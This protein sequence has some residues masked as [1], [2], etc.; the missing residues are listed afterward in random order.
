[1]DKRNFLM[2]VGDPFQ[3]IWPTYMAEWRHTALGD[4]Q[5]CIA[6]SRFFLFFSFA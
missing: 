1:M 3:V 4:I 5:D 6:S 2:G